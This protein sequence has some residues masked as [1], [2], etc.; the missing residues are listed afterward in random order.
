MNET[1]SKLP[2]ENFPQNST[3]HAARAPPL[4]NPGQV[5]LDHHGPRLRWGKRRQRHLVGGDQFFAFGGAF[6]VLW[7]GCVCGCLL[8]FS[9]WLLG[10]LLLCSSFLVSLPWGSFG[11]P[12]G[13][14]LSRGFTRER[15]KNTDIAVV[16]KTNGSPFWLVAAPPMFRTYSSGDW[17]VNWGYGI[18]THGH[19]PLF[20]K[21]RARRL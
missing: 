9:F 16:V 8:A 4:R 1:Y 2:T 11:L 13:V 10:V 12:F 5:E 6:S 18:L 19:I 17:D 14:L 7:R 20:G 3:P 15:K 21:A